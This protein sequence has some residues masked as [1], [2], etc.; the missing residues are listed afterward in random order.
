V[1]HRDLETAFQH[2]GYLNLAIAARVAAATGNAAAVEAVLRERG[3]AE[4]AAQTID[5]TAADVG[6]ARAILGSVSTSNVT[7]SVHD[8]VELGLLSRAG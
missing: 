4:L 8:L 7:E 6:A 5:L 3:G 1:R 2:H